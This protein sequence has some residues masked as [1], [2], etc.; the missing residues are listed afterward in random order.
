[1]FLQIVLELKIKIYFMK[2]IISKCFKKFGRKNGKKLN[3][4]CKINVY[5]IE[6]IIS[7]K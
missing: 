7:G 2:I 3:L 5:N 4:Y 1:M 6:I